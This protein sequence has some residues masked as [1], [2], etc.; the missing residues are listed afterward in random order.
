MF[1]AGI[2][3]GAAIFGAASMIDRDSLMNRGDAEIAFVFL[4]GCAA[5]AVLFEEFQ[6]LAKQKDPTQ[7]VY[8]LGRNV[9]AG[10]TVF[11]GIVALKF[12]HGT[13]VCYR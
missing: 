9:S 7:V 10:L 6:E 12:L 13:L 1:A 4:G 2:L 8:R 3:Q 11:F 5:S